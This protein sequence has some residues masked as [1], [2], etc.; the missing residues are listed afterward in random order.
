MPK[1]RLPDKDFLWTA[2]LAYAVGLLVTDGN[3]S[4]DGRHIN[5]R[6]A[7]IKMLETF[8]KCLNLKNKIGSDRKPDGHIGFRVQFGNVQFYDWLLRVGLMPAKSRIIGAIDIPDQFFPDY[9]RGCIDG[10]GYI[11]TYAD[12]YN[13][14]KGRRYTTQ[15]LFIKIVSAGEQH[16]FWLQEKIKTLAQLHGVVIKRPPRAENYSP[17][18]ELKLAKKES[19]RLARWIYHSPSVPCLERKRRIV[20]NAVA[21]I[22]GQRRRKYEFIKD[23]EI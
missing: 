15:R 14:Y 6:S 1:R 18:W 20:E 8:K 13:L 16:I 11:Q 21:I 19:I 2:Q 22:N 23:S 7:E 3:L 12:T 10:D 9:L 5:M 4:R 17:L